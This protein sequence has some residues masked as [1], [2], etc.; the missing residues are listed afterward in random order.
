VRRRCVAAG[1]RAP[2]GRA[3]RH[4]NVRAARRARDLMSDTIARRAARWCAVRVGQ[5]AAA[6]SDVMSRRSMRRLMAA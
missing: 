1:A 5:M 2:T 4:P 6:V 3:A